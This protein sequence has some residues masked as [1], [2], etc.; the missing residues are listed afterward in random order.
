MRAV[1]WEDLEL[2][3]RWRPYLDDPQRYLL[4]D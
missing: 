2:V 1:A 4:D 3:A